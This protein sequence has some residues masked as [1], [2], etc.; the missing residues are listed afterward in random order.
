MVSISLNFLSVYRKP[1]VKTARGNFP[2][3]KILFDKSAPTAGYTCSIR[4]IAFTSAGCSASELFS[5][6]DSALASTQ[7]RRN[8]RCK[9]FITTWFKLLYTNLTYK[10]QES[11]SKFQMSISVYL[12]SLMSKKPRNKQ[13]KILRSGLS[14]YVKLSAFISLHLL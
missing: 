6:P 3:G 14:K 9:T 10:P 8:L 2:F 13:A 1:F 7:K 5:Q 4:E 12:N 11:Q